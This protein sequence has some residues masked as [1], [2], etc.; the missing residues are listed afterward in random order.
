VFVKKTEI[1][2]LIKLYYNIIK[3]NDQ[4]DLTLRV[5]KAMPDNLD[6]FIGIDDTVAFIV[7][8]YAAHKETVI[9][10]IVH[11]WTLINKLAEKEGAAD[12]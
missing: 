1:K 7:G 12:E 8:Y 3:D 2:R 11:T 10:N 6:S 9:K 5:G 4:L